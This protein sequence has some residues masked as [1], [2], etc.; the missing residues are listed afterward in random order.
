MIPKAEAKNIWVLAEQ[1]KG[2]LVNVSLEAV[3]LAR[4]LA[5]SSSQ[6]VW[7]VLLGKDVAG[8]AE[9]LIQAG[10]DVVLLAEDDRLAGFRDDPYV[11]YLTHLVGVYKPA[12]FIIGANS[13]GKSLAPRL[14]TRL[15]TGL[16]SDCVELS[17]DQADGL[18]AT[19]PMYG[20]NVMA[21]VLCPEARPQLASLRPKSAPR[22][23][24]D[25]SRKGRIEKADLSGVNVRDRVRLLEQVDTA[26]DQVKLEEADIIVSGG[27]GVGGPEKFS[28]IKGLADACKGAMGASRAAVDAGW[29]PYTHQVGQTGKTVSPKVYVACGISGAI[30][31]LAGM[32]SSDIIVAI[33]KNPDAPIFKVATLGIVGDLFEI[34]PMLTEAVK[35]E[36]G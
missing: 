8:L 2:K 15:G 23:V 29:V 18:V 9:S 5:G 28:V 24:P 10:A 14:A 7:A 3:G 36:M 30:Q 1:R 6:E 13:T 33:N 26:G 12:A 25:P 35:K 27:R 20:G 21:T 17:W 11:D 32:K 19:R 16:A 22:P 31:H 34:V 4:N